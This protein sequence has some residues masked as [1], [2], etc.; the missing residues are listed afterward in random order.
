[1]IQ[2]TELVNGIAPEDLVR[3]IVPVFDSDKQKVT[4]TKSPTE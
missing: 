4:R 1:M 2:I 3:P